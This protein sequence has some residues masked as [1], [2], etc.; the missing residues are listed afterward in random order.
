MCNTDRL[1]RERVD[2]NQGILQELTSKVMGCFQWKIHGFPSNGVLL[3]ADN[4][5]AHPAART[6]AFVCNCGYEPLPHPSYSPSLAPS[7]FF[8]FPNMK[9]HLW[10]RGFCN[11]E[12]VSTA[13]ESWFVPKFVGFCVD[14]FK[15]LLQRDPGMWICREG[16]VSVPISDP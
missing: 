11:D 13:V 16:R 10:G 3:L 9:K 1:L 7:D 8:P 14:G 4:A 12:Q 5:P 15:G 2:S 6:V